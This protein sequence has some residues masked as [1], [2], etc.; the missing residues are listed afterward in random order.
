[1]PALLAFPLT[2]L[3]QH[4]YAV[5]DIGSNS[6]R[7]VVYHAPARVPVPLFNEKYYC[8]LGKGL[9]NT[10]FLS[11]ESMAL[12]KQAVARFT[13]MAKRLAVSELNIIATAA[14]R[15][16]RNGAH[17]VRDLEM[18][19][20]IDIDIISGEREAELAAK[21]ALASIYKPVGITADMGG[22][23][24]ELAYINCD[25]IEKQSSFELGTLRLVDD[26]NNNPHVMHD[27]IR[28]E[29]NQVEWLAEVGA[30]TIYAI[31]GSFRS[32][33]KMHMKKTNYPL[34][35]LH[36]YRLSRKTIESMAR[37]LKSLSTEQIALLPG[38]PDERA[39][40]ILPAVLMLHQIMQTA[41]ADQVVFSV[42]G[43]REGLIYDQLSPD[44]QEQDPLIASAY[45]LASLAGRKGAY[46]KELFD[47]MKPLFKREAQ[48]HQR[49]RMALCVL[50]ELAWTVDP[51][52]RS[53]WA[54]L[55]VVQSAMKGMN[56]R[57][58]VTLATALYHRYQNKWKLDRPEVK[59]LDEYDK[60]WARCVGMAANLAFHLS[61]GKHG[62]LHHARLVVEG[63][64]VSLKLD[65]EASP[66]RTD[67]VEK[68]LEGLG[69]TFKALSNFAI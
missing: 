46:A 7:M 60:L 34:P 6:V 53:E 39:I 33:A 55:R 14:V 25:H 22:G 17:F 27:L 44:L 1:M 18:S 56:H 68:R 32:I 30:K 64:A 49:L 42:T 23:S 69:S 36:E 45:D 59:L 48:T 35:I 16:A 62:N 41:H 5:I 57:E 10:G 26:S 20:G 43:I 54:F 51:N 15:D 9:A 8:A 12:A 66:L 2:N 50:S 31:G 29:I 21:G 19:L 13:V 24:I 4:S 40:T 63:N 61:G 65:D 37:S 52:F 58:R 47:W 38:V 3:H 11:A 67:T 28:R